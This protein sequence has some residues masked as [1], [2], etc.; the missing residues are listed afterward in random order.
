MRRGIEV[1]PER[2]DF[3]RQIQGARLVVTGE[4]SLDAQTLRGKAPAGVARAAAA[5]GGAGPPGARAPQPGGGG[6][7]RRWGAGPWTRGRTPPR[8]PRGRAPSHTPA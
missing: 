6:P 8:P 7:R 3:A 4:G 2:L 5:A 1:R